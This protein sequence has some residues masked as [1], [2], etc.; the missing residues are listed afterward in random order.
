MMS[1]GKTH[2]T[3]KILDKLE[4]MFEMTKGDQTSELTY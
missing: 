1:L 4:N 2:E 3:Q